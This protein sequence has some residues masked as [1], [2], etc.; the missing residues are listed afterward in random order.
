VDL[1]LKGKTALVTGASKGIGRAVAEALA[2]EGCELHLCARTEAQLQAAKGALEQRRGAKVTI[3]P[4]DLSKRGAPRKLADAVGPIDLLVNN[5]GAIPAGSLG[6]IDEDRW[7]AAWDLK[8]FGYIDLSRVVLAG[9]AARG[10][11]VIVNVIGL[12]GVRPDGGYI[13]GSAGNAALNAFTRALGGEAID[14]G[15]RVVGVNPGLVTTER[16]ITLME[17]RAQKILGDRKRWRELTEYLPLGRPAEPEEVADVV[18]FLASARA[19]YVNGVVLDIDGGVGARNAP[20]A[21]R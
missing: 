14:K 5:A 19:A 11:G 12:A 15:V 4:L 2:A 16:L 3:H 10:R 13:A 7:R 6:D 1:E 17:A 8:V 9:M 21:K 20:Q 18:A